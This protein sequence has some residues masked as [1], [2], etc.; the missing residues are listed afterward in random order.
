MKRLLIAAVVS[1]MLLSC[2]LPKDTFILKG[3]ISGAVDGERIT[4]LY[5]ILKDGVWYERELS[6]TVTEVE[7][8]EIAERVED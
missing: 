8:L 3:E 6:T 5:P 7:W 2:S 1:F 4:L